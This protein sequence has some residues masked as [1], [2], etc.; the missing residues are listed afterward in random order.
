MKNCARRFLPDD[1]T[2]ELVCRLRGIWPTNIGFLVRRLL[3]LSS[4]CGPRVMWK[5]RWVRELRSAKLF[6]T[7]CCRRRAQ[8]QPRE[9]GGAAFRFLPT[10][11]D[12]GL[13]SEPRLVPHGHFARAN[14]RS[15]FFL[16]TFG[17]RWQHDVCGACRHVC[18][19]VGKHWD[20]VRFAKPWPN[21]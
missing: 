8:N 12:C 11:D 15:M 9:P 5:A 10:H 6:P 13:C 21:T 14:L 2:R 20:I 7:S 1:C 18:S 16:R 19:L 3:P 17:L 4:S